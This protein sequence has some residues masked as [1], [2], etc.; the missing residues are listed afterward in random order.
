MDVWRRSHGR[1]I[2]KYGTARKGAT[3]KGLVQ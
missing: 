2:D 3:Q 1:H